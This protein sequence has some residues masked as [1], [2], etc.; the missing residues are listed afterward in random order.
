MDF[1]PIAG[2]TLL[3]F[4]AGYIMPKISDFNE[5]KLKRA[6]LEEIHENIYP[7]LEACALA[8]GSL[9]NTPRRLAMI[10][11]QHYIQSQAKCP[12][13]DTDLL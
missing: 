1:Q 2:K 7:G 6:K 12:R 4:H 9:E 13:T 8:L 5:E 10:L 11:E 3:S